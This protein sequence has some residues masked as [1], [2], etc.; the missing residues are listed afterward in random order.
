MDILHTEFD[1]VNSSVCS[2]DG[3]M[4]HGSMHSKHVTGACHCVVRQ[5][6]VLMQ[7]HAAATLVRTLTQLDL[8]ARGNAAEH[9]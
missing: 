1:V 2:P 6:I 3:W 8:F 7:Q 5:L 4:H 9:R